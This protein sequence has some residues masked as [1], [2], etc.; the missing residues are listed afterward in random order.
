M[1]EKF[2]I[3]ASDAALA[4]GGETTATWTCAESTG[5]PTDAEIGTILTT[6]GNDA[7]AVMDTSPTAAQKAAVAF[8]LLDSLVSSLDLNTRAKRKAFKLK[9]GLQELQ[10]IVAAL[11]IADQ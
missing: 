10:D 2:I 1:A 6:A 3:N 7:V 8:C 5:A 11:N 9:Q 4:V